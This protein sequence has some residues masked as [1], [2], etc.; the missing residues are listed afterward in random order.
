ML[1]FF[2]IQN[3]TALDL[4]RLPPRHLFFHAP[5]VDGSI[6]SPL[7]TPEIYTWLANNLEPQNLFI[8]NSITMCS[9]FA[10]DLNL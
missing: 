1:A 5:G 2:R 7:A 4:R 3:P 9:I 10:F 6:C 8:F